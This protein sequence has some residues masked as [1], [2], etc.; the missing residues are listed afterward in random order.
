MNKLQWLWLALCTL[1]VLDLLTT[2]I[3]LSL[4]AVEQNPLGVLA[5][6][7]GFSGLVVMKVIATLTALGITAVLVKH[8]H[9]KK[10]EFGSMISVGMMALVVASNTTIIVLHL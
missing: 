2:R 3:G 5:L 4:G 9:W 7:F 6:D 8:N 1:Q 10:A